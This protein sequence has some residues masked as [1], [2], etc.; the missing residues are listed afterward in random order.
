MQQA[1]LFVLSIFGLWQ[2]CGIAH[3]YPLLQ[4]NLASLDCQEAVHQA[5]SELTIRHGVSIK[6]VAIDRA[7]HD[8]NPYPN[9]QQVRYSIVTRHGL[10]ASDM[11]RQASWNAENLMNSPRLLEHIAH[12]IILRCPEVSIV[13][14]EISNSSYSIPVF[15]M[16]SGQVRVGVPVNI[17]CGNTRNAIP[18]RL[19]W[20]YFHGGC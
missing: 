14:F 11:E 9:S 4:A 18:P 6:G 15:R 1:V 3:G 20:G 5:G 19:Q 16:R 7:S 12:S 13:V 2:A 8:S 17:E 10:N